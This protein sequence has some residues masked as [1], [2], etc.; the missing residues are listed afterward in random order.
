MNFISAKSTAL[1]E[2]L[3]RDDDLDGESNSITNQKRFLEDYARKNGFSNICH[4]TDDGYSGTN[5]DRPGFTRMMKDVEDGRIGTIIVKD[6]SRFGRNYLQV[7]FYTEMRFPKKDVRFIAV[8]NGVDSSK[9]SDNDFTPFLNIM[10]EWYAKD[11]S[12][13]IKAIF[14]ARMEDGLRCS[15]AIPYGY[16]T[17]GDK[18][19]LVVDPEAAEVVRHIFQLAYSGM[20][21]TMIAEQLTKEH[22]LIPRAYK[23]KR[24]GAKRSNTYYDP[25]HWNAVTIN[26]I[27]TS[28]EYLGHTVLNKE[29]VENFKLKKRRIVPEEERFFFPNTHE[30]IIDQKTW[31]VVQKLMKRHP[32]RDKEGI[33]ISSRLSGLVVCADC[34]RKMSYRLK[35][36]PKGDPTLS[37][38]SF[39]CP[40]YR[41]AKKAPDGARVCENHYVREDI[42]EDAVRLTVQSAMKNA[43]TDESGFVA[44]IIDQYEKNH[45]QLSDKINRQ[46]AETKKRM[47]EIGSLV[48]K[49]YESYASGIIPERQFRKLTEDYDAEQTQLDT[50]Y[51]EL[52]DQMQKSEGD[53][54]DPKRFVE[55][56]RK[57]KDCTEISDEMLY[58]FVDRIVVH[59]REKVQ[60][61]HRQKI[62]VYLT[63]LGDCQIIPELSEEEW[64]A[65]VEEERKKH[66]KEKWAQA[67]Q[68]R[69]ERV[70]QIMRDAE[71]DPEAAKKAEELKTKAH[72]RYLENKEKFQRQLLDDPERLEQKRTYA[73]EAKRRESRERKERLQ[74]LQENLPEHPEYAQEL[75]EIQK[76]IEERRAKNRKWSNMRNARIREQRRQDPEFDRRYREKQ[77][78][79]DR[80]KRDRY[81]QM[82]ALAETDEEA[83]RK[84]EEHRKYFRE[85]ARRVRD[86][87]EYREK[88]RI[89]MREYLKDPEHAEANRRKA[90]DYYYRKKAERKKAEGQISK[91]RDACTLFAR[92]RFQGKGVRTT[93]TAIH[94]PMDLRLV[95]EEGGKE[96]DLLVEKEDRVA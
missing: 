58:Q 32:R 35:K 92:K 44:S 43:I 79:Y 10:N 65:R 14:H 29:V 51:Q 61:Y 39:Q 57:Y 56:V 1:Y 27:L 18:Q 40:Q 91:I 28:N 23:E 84:V 66:L 71:S 41:S 60:G 31:D 62:D 59:K 37:G 70:K 9:P 6:M 55:L 7:G 42:L 73:R 63:F 52:M 67:R 93:E 21:K 54:L 16:V 34:G 4:Y 13:K 36:V 80:R 20:G 96:I 95:Y 49:L 72:E 46:I 76:K 68:R 69:R 11:T 38:Y 64:V 17:K 26:Q 74:F 48:R 78:E 24:T 25:Y 45:G 8:V 53:R 15:G 88:A 3:S 81:R 83:A 90:K 47:D 89:Q 50:K 30:P 85:R 94:E 75:E 87:D 5:F 86:T 77:R 82:V 22:V 19:T 2:R 12:K 33:T